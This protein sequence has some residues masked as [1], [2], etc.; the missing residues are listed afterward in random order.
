MKTV[1]N[2]YLVL[3]VVFTVLFGLTGLT[4]A[5]NRSDRDIRDAMRSL[6][7]KLDDFEQNARYQMQSSSASS[8]DVSDLMDA[9]RN[10]RDRTREFQANYDRRRENRDDVNRI[11]DAARSIDEFLRRNPQNR[12]VEDDWAAVR[13]QIERLGANYGVTPNWNSDPDPTWMPKDRN[14]PVQKNTI[15]VGLSGTYD[16]DLVRSENIEDIVSDTS[17]G[18]EQRADLREKL[19]APT[20]I[21]LDIR[22]NHVTLA[23]ANA[24]PITFVADGREKTETSPSGQTIRVR[25]TLNGPNL[26]LTSLGGE[27]DYTIAFTSLSSGSAMKVTRRITTDY[28][29]QTVIAESIYNKTDSVARLGIPSASG[30]MPDQTGGYSDND[31]SGNTSGGGTSTRAPISVTTRPGNY[32]V[33]NGV[34]ING[35]LENEINTKISQNNDRFRLTVQSPDEF[36]G[37]TVQGYIVLAK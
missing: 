34:V 15:T 12:R 13:R 29:N 11:V 6:N 7:S 10:V 1:R 16:L 14:E 23:T 36:R 35:I 26:V 37:A 18:T 5:Q 17:L 19:T 8:S 24:S 4:T 33:P 3:F 27:T 20:Q 21:A 25:A 9:V 31:Q 32:I 22:G 30:S 2:R 28:L